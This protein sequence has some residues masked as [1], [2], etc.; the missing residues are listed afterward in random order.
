MG[1]AKQDDPIT[2]TPRFPRETGKREKLSGTRAPD[3]G[4]EYAWDDDEAPTQ[5]LRSGPV[6]KMPSD[7]PTR[8]PSEM[9]APLPDD[10]EEASRDHRVSAMR[11]LYAAGDTDAA[12]FIAQLIDPSPPGK[13]SLVAE[14]VRPPPG[15]EEEVAS[16]N[17]LDA[18]PRTLLGSLEIAALP[19]HHREGFLLAHIDGESTLDQILDICAMPEQEAA[20]I[21]RKLLALGVI[22]FKTG[23]SKRR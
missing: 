9:R 14:T 17:S 21:L 19:L 11:E 5:K 6:P 20:T 8:I 3:S 23:S 10:P 4:V 1:G 22:A 13:V 12:L 15:M 16:I 2:P 7:Y 18:V